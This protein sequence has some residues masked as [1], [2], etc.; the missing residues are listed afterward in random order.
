M[1]VEADEQQYAEESF[2]EE[3][4]S[5]APHAQG[6]ART[7][8][9][10]DETEAAAGDSSVLD[11]N[12]QEFMELRAATAVA[13]EPTTTGKNEIPPEMRGLDGMSPLPHQI[14]AFLYDEQEIS[15]SIAVSGGGESKADKNRP[16]KVLRSPRKKKAR[17]STE[18]SKARG[19]GGIPEGVEGSVAE[20]SVDSSALRGLVDQMDSVQTRLSSLRQLQRERDSLAQEETS[21]SVPPSPV[22]VCVADGVAGGGALHSVGQ[23]RVSEVSSSRRVSRHVLTGDMEAR[24]SH[25]QREVYERDV[26][27]DRLSK[28]SFV[29]AQDC[30]DLRGE[31]SRLRAQVKQE[32]ERANRET[33]GSREQ[34]LLEAVEELSLQNEELILRL[35][36]SM[37]REIA[38]RRLIDKSQVKRVSAAPRIQQQQQVA[39]TPRAPEPRRSSSDQ[40]SAPRGAMQRRVRENVLNLP[41]LVKK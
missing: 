20:S 29:L 24:V 27:L 25:L 35:R 19:G 22:R 15:D 3:T 5:S 28:N 21:G 36:S 4:P 17:Q 14:K 31:V 39:V 18:L 32:R 11:M 41:P 26:L 38:L 37:E 7:E 1:S 40:G 16:R 8:E 34:A 23:Q 2:E 6:E 13:S 9:L 12:L 33:G 10:L 30:D